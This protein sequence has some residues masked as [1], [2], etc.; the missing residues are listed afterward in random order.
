MDSQEKKYIKMTTA[1][2]KPLILKLSV[3]TIASM[4]VTTFYNA[5]DT[6]FVGKLSNDSIT[7]AVGVVFSLMAIIQAVGFFFGHG[8]G[9]YISRELGKKNI[10]SAEKMASVGFF[11]ALIAGTVI[12]GAG[13]VFLEPLANLLGSTP[14]ILPYAEQYMRFILLGAPYMTAQLVLNN[15]LRFQGNALFAMIG[16]VSGAVLNIG[17]DPLF[18]FVF[19]MGISG[20]ALATIISQAVSFILL[21]IGVQKS[22]NLTIRL[23]N[24]KPTLHFLKQICVG[25]F[26]SLCRQGI[27]AL[28]TVFLNHAAGVYG[29]AAVAAFTVVQKIMMFAN[30]ALIGFGQGFQP[31]CGFN[32][33]ARKYSRVREAFWFCVLSG[34]GF[35]LVLSGFAYV[36]AEQ[37]I[38]LF[39]GSD[40]VLSIGTRIFRAQLITFPVMSFVV[41]SN[42]MMQNIGKVIRASLLAMSRQ[43]LALIPAIWILSA[44]AGLDGLIWAQPVSDFA[45][46]LLAVPIQIVVLVS[47]KK[48]IREGRAV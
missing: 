26:P 45:A 44:V 40:A 42:M 24:F 36:L 1:P 7:S 5:A 20:A 47:M 6:F 37:I 21:F 32:W 48:A 29:D 46:L 34:F 28:S 17:L 9:N 38:G 14:S 19:D 25:G 31:V 27:A 2:V 3:P 18:I 8:S 41:L 10:E 39:G 16:I 15:Q 12:M 11:S 35:L 43:G 33:G 4:M 22:D 23:R 30:S 13:L